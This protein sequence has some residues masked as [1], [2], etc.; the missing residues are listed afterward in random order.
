MEAGNKT[1]A[2]E[3]KGKKSD[4]PAC[5]IGCVRFE[6]FGKNCWY[7]WEGKKHCTMW[8]SDWDEAAM[9]QF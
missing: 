5:C 9:Q 7:Y 1:E 8:T 4:V 6:S 2:K 3:E